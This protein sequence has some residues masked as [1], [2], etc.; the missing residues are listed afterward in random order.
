[1]SDIRAFKLAVPQA[2]IDDL[3]A[4]LDR[5]LWP[6][7]APTAPWADRKSVV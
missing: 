6:D 5:T 2:A 3:H 7:E 4:R 1:M